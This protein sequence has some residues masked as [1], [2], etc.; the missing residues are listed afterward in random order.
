MASVRTST[1]ASRANERFLGRAVIIGDSHIHAIKDALQARGSNE[2][3]IRIEAKRLLKV[4]HLP[5]PAKN[6]AGG[7][8][9]SAR[10]LLK[11]GARKTA[12]AALGDI[13]FDEA[14]K[15]AR[16]LGPEDI[17]VSVIGGNQHAVFS[18]IQHPQPFDFMLP[19]EATQDGSRTNTELVPFRAL[20]PYFRVALRDGDGETIAALRKATSA[21]MIH[22][23]APP[24]KRMN[25]WIEQ[26]HDTM[27][28]EEGLTQQGVSKPELRLR[29]WHLQNRAIHEICGELGVEVLGTPPGASDA[30]GFLARAY[31]AG[32]ATHANPRYGELVL[33]QLEA[34]LGPQVVAREAVS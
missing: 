28:V 14:L 20:Y 29:F 16:R 2:S 6:E 11:G 19:G 22:L 32:D 25:D 33:Q 26:H 4:K 13:S 18:T 30:D 17:L 34:M 23:L 9:A 15:I 31:Y 1:S 10:K 5:Y 24:P 3:A 7:L 21:R 8:L 27:F 12:T